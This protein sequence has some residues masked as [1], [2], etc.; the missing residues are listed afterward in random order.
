M[1]VGPDGGRHVRHYLF[2]FGSIIGGGPGFASQPRAGNEYILDWGKGF[3]TLASFGF[4][5]RPWLRV[6]YPDTPGSV[7]RFEAESFDPL[8]WR[9][10][11]PNPAFRNLMPDDAY[12]AARIVSRFSDDAI[13]AVVAEAR[14]S[15]PRATAYVADTLIARCDAIARYWL[16]ELNPIHDPR[17]D[18]QG[19][20]TFDN[21]VVA[22]GVATEPTDYVLTWY[23][24]DNATA[25]HTQ[26]GEEIWTAGPFGRIPEP[27]RLD[28]YAAVLVRGIHPVLPGWLR[29]T[30]VHFRR[31]ARGWETVGIER[32]VDERVPTTRRPTG[33]RRPWRRRR[34]TTNER[35]GVR[36]RAEEMPCS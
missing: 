19:R 18:G 31:T 3:K 33:G 4:Y 9:P 13:R 24:V 27:L 32:A 23:R 35:V 22:A 14:Y 36:T 30:R 7:G 17:L 12:W 20:L 25:E 28:D 21:A 16:N 29:A 5:R 2:D 6:Q 1:L 10:E 15:D 11:Y 8:A 34:H 26:V